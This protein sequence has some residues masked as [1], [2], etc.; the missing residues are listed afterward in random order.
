MYVIDSSAP[1]RFEESKEALST[2]LSDD[3]LNGVPLL[4]IASKQ[5]AVGA[6][7]SQD[8]A[9]F[10]GLQQLSSSRK[11]GIAGVKILVNGEVHGIQEAK[12]LI[13]NFCK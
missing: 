3:T 13:L 1:Q 11:T 4:L 6:K 5:D 10:F 7:P 9:S 2:V 8:V 12:E